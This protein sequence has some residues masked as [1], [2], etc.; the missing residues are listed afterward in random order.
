MTWRTSGESGSWARGPDV[1]TQP[2]VLLPRFRLEETSPFNCWSLHSYMQKTK[3]QAV[4]LQVATTLP[5]PP[6][7]CRG[8]GRRGGGR[9][10]KGWWL[11]RQW[12]SGMQ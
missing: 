2:L 10:G 11:C 12:Q 3:R 1:V 6:L 8:R 7:V 5:S 4:Q 9:E